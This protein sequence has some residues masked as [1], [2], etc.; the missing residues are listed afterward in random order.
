MSKYAFFAGLA[1]SSNQN[2]TAISRGIFLFSEFSIDAS[3]YAEGT[4]TQKTPNFP[5]SLASAPITL[6]NTPTSGVLTNWN[7]G[8]LN[9]TSNGPISISNT[10]LPAGKFLQIGVVNTITYR[11]ATGDVDYADWV[12][13]LQSKSTK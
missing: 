12:K 13:C 1:D 4:L 8:S 2:A 10:S 3:T 9:T 6:N 5:N 7:G 11:S